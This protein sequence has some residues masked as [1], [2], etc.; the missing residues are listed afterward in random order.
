M[1]APARQFRVVAERTVSRGVRSVKIHYVKVKKMRVDSYRSKKNPEYSF[2]VQAFTDLSTLGNDD[3]DLLRLLE[4]I[5]LEYQN[6]ELE[7]L[8]IGEEFDK[9]LEELEQSGS[10]MMKTL[11]R[12]VAEPEDT[13][14]D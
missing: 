2:V 13:G 11:Y 5:E 9:L 7:I 1:D 14:I 3:Q 12:E 8:V 6:I 10:G 4:P